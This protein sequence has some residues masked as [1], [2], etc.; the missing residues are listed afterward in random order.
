M[1]AAGKRLRNCSGVLLSKSFAPL[2]PTI[3]GVADP[4]A[5]AEGL[6][7]AKKKGILTTQDYHD[8]LQFENLNVLVELTGVKTVVEDIKACK[9]DRVKLIDHLEVFVPVGFH[10]D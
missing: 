6:V 2:R 9:P 7:Y 10:S 4:D 8:L 1:S 5:Q 3:I